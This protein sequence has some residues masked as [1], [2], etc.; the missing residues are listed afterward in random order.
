[1]S[2]VRPWTGRGRPIRLPLIGIVSVV[3]VACTSTAAPSG[4]G[5]GASP[6]GSPGSMVGVP[7]PSGTV[8]T[9]AGPAARTT[10]HVNGDEINGWWW[11]R[12]AAGEQR[13]SWEFF[14]TPTAEDVTLDIEVLA[15]D[16]VDGRPRVDAR[17]WLSY[18]TIV[19]AAAAPPRSDPHLVV[20]PNTS[21]SGDPV[22]Y[23]TTG[24]YT[25][26]RS[27]VAPGAIGIWVRIERAGPDGSVVREHIAVRES[28]VLI[29]G[30]IGPDVTPGPTVIPPGGSPGASATVTPSGAG[31]Y[32]PLTIA[33]G[34]QLGNAGSVTVVG[35]AAPDLH[36]EF[37]SDALFMDLYA[38]DPILVLSP[39]S[40]TYQGAYPVESFPDGIWVRWAGAPSITAHASSKGYCPGYT[41]RPSG[42]PRPSPTMPPEPP[43]GTPTIVSI[44][45]SYISG[46][47]GRW[48]GNS[49]EAYT[50]VDAG[51]SDAYYDNMSRTAEVI[52]G[53][54]RSE[55]AEV[56]IDR[57]GLLRVATINL[58]C[59]GATTQTG[60]K[61][62]VDSCPVDI[63]RSDCPSGIKGQVTLLGEVARQHNVKLVVLS[64]GGNDFEFSDTV[65]TCA[66][67]FA[68]SL[69]IWSDY[70]HDDQPVLARFSAFN[71]L[72]VQEKLFNAYEDIVIAMEDAGY[73]D[74]HWT[75]LI[76]NY[77]SPLPPGGDIRYGEFSMSRFNNG[78]PF[79]S[80]DA[81]WANDTALPT[82]KGAIEGAVA[83]FKVSYPGIDIH[84]LDV[85][86]A[87]VGHRLCEDTVDLV[88]YDKPVKRWSDAGASDG[89]EWVAAIR[90]VWSQG[91][92][93]PLPGSV[94]Y[95][96]ES[97]HPNYWGQLALRNCLRQAW[98]GGDVQGGTCTFVGNGANAYGEPHMHLATE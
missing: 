98:N 39:P 80:D 47:A 23:T 10:F 85:S 52:P 11:L 48:A 14:G 6:G 38:E 53:C 75:L 7:L 37:S 91:G 93:L 36:L 24:S 34:C 18:G 92:E 46:E 62:G 97:F 74:D 55:S 54:H 51:G 19:S 5:A 67:D 89:S 63:H 56:H 1:M 28:S 90:G 95:K 2:H 50:L 21:P 60:G 70:C 83:S 49:N 96:N 20:L 45:D 41:P 43:T 78:C 68:G 8:S 59:S 94:Y 77:P 71:V 15:T 31:L 33:T 73:P 12:D 22:G 13:A 40:Y 3:L 16:T 86:Q 81:D 25:L 58:A 64:V 29:S 57:N 35:S 79:W 72:L 69:D 84:L 88:G 66:K 65:A 42:T 82:I 30:L 27:E 87:L 44:G 26:P 32:G 9:T 4:T 17:F 61:P 76:Q